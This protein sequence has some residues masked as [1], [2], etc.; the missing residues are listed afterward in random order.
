MGSLQRSCVEGKAKPSSPHHTNP[1]LNFL[2][3]LVKSKCKVKVTTCS[4]VVEGCLHGYDR[5]LHNGIGSLI[6]ETPCGHVIVRSW[7]CIGESDSYV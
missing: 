7:I 1:S 3:R 5:S 6:M 2:K 4:G